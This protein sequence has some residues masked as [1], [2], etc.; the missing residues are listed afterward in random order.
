MGVITSSLYWS[1]P[2]PKEFGQ[3]ITDAC[4]NARVVMLSFPQ[5][6]PA[7]IMM[8]LENALKDANIYD[9]AMLNIESGMDI[10]S[11]IATH[12]G[13]AHMPAQS[14]A[15]HVHRAQ[16]AVVLTA[17]GSRAQEQCEKYMREFTNGMEHAT[18]NVSLIVLIRSGE[19]QRD[20]FKD[21]IRII[22]FDGSLRPAEMEAYVSQR[23]VSYPGPGTTNLYRHL[24]TEYAAFDATLAERLA[25][26]DSSKILGLPHSL[27]EILGENL[28]RWSQQTWLAG[29]L[30]HSSKELHPVHEWHRATYV[31]VDANH[32]ARLVEKRYWRACLKALMPW[33]E[34]RRQGIL[35]MLDRPLKVLEKASGHGTIAKRIG[36]RT[37]YVPRHELEYNDLVFYAMQPEFQ[38]I[39]LTM[40]EL[41]AIEA[42]SAA[43]AVRDELSHLRPPRVEDISNLVSQ[44]DYLFPG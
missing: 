39:N 8:P 34:E 32:F 13:A 44:M 42:C 22:S 37:I 28:L 3:K 12:F 24:V 11:Q 18:G 41:K 30:C 38:S 21:G 2:G 17:Q 43:K 7:P 25:A 40:P 23:M 19:H 36:S 4:R 1:L 16:H 35:D 27:S 26:M 29:T 10:S 15:N 31:G 5:Y 6:L 9:P 33:M 20:E 14:L